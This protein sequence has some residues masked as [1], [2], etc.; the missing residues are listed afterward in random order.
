MKKMDKHKRNAYRYLDKPGGLF[1]TRR[2]METVWAGEKITCA[3]KF[4]QL[5]IIL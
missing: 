3:E 1:L 4:V 2:N 5:K